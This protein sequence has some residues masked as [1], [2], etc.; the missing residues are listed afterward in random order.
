MTVARSVA[1]VLERHVTLEVECIDR[2]YL[3][4]YVPIL[5]TEEGV[6]HFFR[7]HRGHRFASSSLMAP[8]S[9]A[10]VSS[11]ERFAKQEGIDVVAFE[12]GSARRR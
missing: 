8:M 3:N 2:M 7:Q 12:K 9:R 5:Q 11:I 10:L 1:V 6:A 4:A